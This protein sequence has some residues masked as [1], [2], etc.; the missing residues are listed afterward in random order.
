V[1]RNSVPSAV[2]T[3]WFPFHVTPS[4]EMRSGGAPAHGI[5][6]CQCKLENRRQVRITAFPFGVAAPSAQGRTWRKNKVLRSV[7]N[8]LQPTKSVHRLTGLP[9]VL[10]AEGQD[11]GRAWRADRRLRDGTHASVG[12]RAAAGPATRFAAGSRASTRRAVVRVALAPPFRAP[13][14]SD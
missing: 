10:A 1:G 2:A 5:R 13:L 11:V 9:L 8:R 4:M 3:N 6:L 14:I 12:S 7:N